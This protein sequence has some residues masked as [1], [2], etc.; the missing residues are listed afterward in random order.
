MR[1][2]LYTLIVLIICYC[3]LINSFAQTESQDYLTDASLPLPTNGTKVRT[4]KPLAPYTTYRIKITSPYNL[5]PV[6]SESQENYE[7][8]ILIDEKFPRAISFDEGTDTHVSNPEFIYRG[9][10]KQIYIGFT[11][12]HYKEIEQAQIQ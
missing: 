4:P 9:Y 10:G 7:S 8:D 3:C 6:Y 2:H 11:R 1:L 5:R 12:N